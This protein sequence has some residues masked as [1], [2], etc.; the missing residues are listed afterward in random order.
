M[1]G[2]TLSHYHITDHIMQDALVEAH[3]RN[4]I[5]RDIN[6]PLEP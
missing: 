3:R 1:I 2:Q 5:H 4:I 6:P